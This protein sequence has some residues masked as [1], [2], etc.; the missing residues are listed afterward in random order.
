MTMNVEAIKYRREF[1]AAFNQSVSLLKSRT[2]E[3]SMTEGRTAVFDVTAIGGR[4]QQRSI[5]GRIPRTNISDTQVSATLTEFVKKFEVT[6]FEAFTSQSDERAKMNH[7]IME[8][9]NQEFDFT[10]LNELAN[11]ANAYSGLAA[12]ITLDGATKVIATLANNQVP[13]SPENVTWVIS[14]FM[15]AKLQT[16]PAY[17]SADYIDVKVLS[18]GANQYDGTAKVKV[19]LNVA[20]VVHPNLAGSGTSDCATY[21]WHKR[22]IGAAVPT[23]QMKYAAGYDDQDH[24]HYCSATAKLNAKIL[25]Q[26]GV[27]K[28]KHNDTA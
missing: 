25:Q 14:P 9:V 18:K 6:D 5:D 4:M 27:L 12:A 24:Y 8:S 20:W 10:L 22:A 23:S 17:T 21:I 1:V 11:A 26:N 13:I 3:E 19:W 7:R 2:L 16:I 15:E 28:F